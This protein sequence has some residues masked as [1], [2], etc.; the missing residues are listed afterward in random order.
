VVKVRAQ[1]GRE[2]YSG[3]QG[4]EQI[5]GVDPHHARPVAQGKLKSLSKKVGERALLAQWWP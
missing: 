4:K 2:R 3:K 5:D 1:T